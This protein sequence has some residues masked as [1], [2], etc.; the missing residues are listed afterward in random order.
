MKLNQ[1]RILK[2]SMLLSLV[3]TGSSSL[4]STSQGANLEFKKKCVIKTMDNL[5]PNYSNGFNIAVRNYLND[6]EK[7]RDIEKLKDLIDNRNA[8][9]R[10]N[11]KGN[12][13]WAK[14]VLNTAGGAVTLPYKVLT[15]P[16][17]WVVCSLS[18]IKGVASTVSQ[19]TTDV[20]D[21]LCNNRETSDASV[22]SK[23]FEKAKNIWGWIKVEAIN[24][25]GLEVNEEN[26]T[27]SRDQFCNLNSSFISKKLELL[28]SNIY[29]SVSFGLDKF[30]N[31]ANTENLSND[32]KETAIQCFGVVSFFFYIHICKQIAKG[33]T[34]RELE[35]NSFIS[36]TEQ[37]LKF[38]E[39]IEQQ[40]KMSQ[41]LNR[42][43]GLFERKNHS[44][45][46]EVENVKKKLS[47][48]E[49]LAHSLL[50]QLTTG[51]AEKA[52]KERELR[53]T[54]TIL[55]NEN[56]NE[57]ELSI[58]L[59]RI[60][61]I[62]ESDLRETHTL[63]RNQK[64]L[65][66]LLRADNEKKDKEIRTN[67]ALLKE[68]TKEL[69]SLK[70]YNK[71]SEIRKSDEKFLEDESLSGYEYNRN[72]HLDYNYFQGSYK[73]HVLR[74]FVWYLLFISL[75]SVISCYTELRSSK[76]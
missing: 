33:K 75:L 23:I 39:K 34:K 68:K 24:E 2:L 17:V 50:E 67:K 60:N 25:D 11:L 10:A 47:T 52:K 73:E 74:Y 27:L 35:L 62:I 9:I 16:S 54:E 55:K 41:Y 51:E 30:C 64:T 56:E 71:I 49:E 45:E 26:L 31:L 4:H 58:S 42:D 20:S 6:L 59:S 63:L 3:I 28:S 76:S 40:K 12:E 38:L 48:Q 72:D 44:L 15:S 69:N 21:W 32:Q 65:S 36:H 1:N 14:A 8:H 37:G 13:S 22:I 7:E 57:K 5:L 66:S 18:Q 29:N 43:N 19:Y 53:A 61:K 46:K 70:K